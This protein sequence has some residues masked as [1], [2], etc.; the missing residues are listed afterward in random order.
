MIHHDMGIFGEQLTISIDER[1]RFQRFDGQ[2]ELKSARLSNERQ[3]IS[4]QDAWNP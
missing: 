4:D 2:D 1:S 3:Q